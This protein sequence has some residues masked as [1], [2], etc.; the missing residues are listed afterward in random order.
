MKLNNISGGVDMYYQS[1]LVYELGKRL[2]RKSN[3]IGK[4]K[5]LFNEH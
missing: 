2:L 5:K 1:T 4:I 3:R